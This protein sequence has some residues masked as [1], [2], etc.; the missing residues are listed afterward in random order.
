MKYI[1]KN[2]C[3]MTCVET[4]VAPRPVALGH[5]LGIDGGKKTTKQI[6][7]NVIFDKQGLAHCTSWIELIH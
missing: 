5:I 3:H 7:C 2:I 1:L 4:L 6:F